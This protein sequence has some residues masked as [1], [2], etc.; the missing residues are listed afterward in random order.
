ME[1]A[2]K[3]EEALRRRRTQEEGRGGNV[4]RQDTRPTW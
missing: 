1:I 3:L 4:R 2:N